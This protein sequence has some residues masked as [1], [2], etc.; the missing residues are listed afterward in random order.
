MALSAPQSRFLRFF[1]LVLGA[2]L[3]SYPLWSRRRS[4]GLGVSQLVWDDFH[5]IR[6]E[7]LGVRISAVMKWD[8]N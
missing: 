1:W 3:L 6:N 7:T 8:F 2:V 5:A 4:D